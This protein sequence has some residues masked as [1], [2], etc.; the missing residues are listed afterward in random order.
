M[1]HNKY[2]HLTHPRYRPD[3][4]GLR[5]TAILAVVIFHA[6]PELV[7]GG[8]IGVDIFFVISGFLISTIIFSSLEHDRFS[9][10]EFY[11]RRIRRIFPALILVLGS[12]MLIG[13]Y[14]L[15]PDEYKQLAKHTTASAGFIQ[16][17]IL[18]HESGYFDNAAEYKPLLHLWSLGIE[19]QFYIFWPLLLALVWRQKWSFLRFTAVIAAVSFF[20][21]IYLILNDSLTAAF[22]LPL[23][24]FWELMTGGVLAYIALHRPQLT[25]R[26]KNLQSSLGSILILV[27]LYLLN[28]ERDF[29]GLW[30]LLP[31]I[32][33]FFIISAGPTSWINRALLSAKPMVW[34][35]L[36]SYPLYLWH[37]PILSFLRIISGDKSG[38]L[39]I[40]LALL[41]STLCAFLTYR[42][43]EIKV[44]KGYR[45]RT[46]IFILL[47]S[48]LASLA[49]AVQHGIFDRYIDPPGHNKA[50]LLQ[51]KYK[52]P[53]SDSCE[54]YKL[55]TP[56]SC[57][58]SIKKYPET[59]MLIGDSH[60]ETTTYGF[61][62]S[63]NSGR[64]PYNLI[65]MGR[66]GCG[67]FYN[68]E[69]YLNGTSLNC[70]EVINFALDYAL[71]H[72]EIKYVIFISRFAARFEG[73]RF[74]ETES[75]L[76]SIKYKYD[77]NTLAL[78]EPKMVFEKG[79]N[80]T[81]ERFAHS[82]K[83]LIFF[84]QTPELGFDVRQCLPPR[85][86]FNFQAC[87][88]QRD[89]VNNRQRGYRNQLIDTAKTHPDVYLYD[90]MD[91]FC[92]EQECGVYNGTGD[93]M[94][95]DDNHITRA[96]SVMVVQHF[97]DTFP[98]H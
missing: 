97:L 29:P 50:N 70:K 69:T 14:V 85:S 38:N 33:A 74:G 22:Y 48:L 37:W 67:P 7:P 89:I 52:F 24:R 60:M 43:I 45:I 62:E 53:Q 81:I 4:D 27:G 34:L 39:A 86:H 49:L 19:E 12:C 54:A 79:L 88:I 11:V 78:F 20:T 66:G 46:F 30:A 77:D 73:D 9:L 10:T 61:I 47:M 31:T 1:S 71:S 8:F 91:M 51:L 80:I 98:P 32:G 84:L 96:A 55:S 82:G 59:I 72:K 5:A 64:L 95:R 28:K 65:A 93:L 56:F 25:S 36:I 58:E 18:W 90:P 17:L 42:L 75:S 2:P 63:F 23:S 44:R 68:S 15:F 76:H 13:W 83:K 41:V 35:G 6:F 40:T 3:I 16:N 57:Y 21:N 26:Y 92:D 94:F 87:T